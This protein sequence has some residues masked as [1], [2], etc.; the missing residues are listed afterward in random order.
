MGAFLSEPG[1]IGKPPSSL[2]SCHATSRLVTPRYETLYRVTLRHASPRYVAVPRR[3]RATSYHAIPRNFMLRPLRFAS[4]HY[5]KLRPTSTGYAT[6]FP[7][8]IALRPT[9]KLTP[10]PSRATLAPRQT[11]RYDASPSFPKRRQA[12]RYAARSALVLKAIHLDSRGQCSLQTDA[13]LPMVTSHFRRRGGFSSY[14]LSLVT[15]NC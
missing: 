10:T 5:V 6:R 3:P 4:S 15:Q 11:T 2:N 7:L 12:P 8:S 14:F 13:R 1:F 9:S